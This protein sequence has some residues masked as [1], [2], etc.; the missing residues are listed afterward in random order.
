MGSPRLDGSSSLRRS[1]LVRRGVLEDWDRTRI[2]CRVSRADQSLRCLGWPRSNRHSRRSSHVQRDPWCATPRF[3]A[4]GLRIRGTQPDASTVVG[5]VDTRRGS[6]SP[7]SRS[8]CRPGGAWT[9]RECDG[10]HRTQLP[11][12]GG[13]RLGDSR[14]AS[15]RSRAGDGLRIR[16]ASGWP[17]EML[18]HGARKPE[19]HARRFAVIDQSPRCH[20]SARRTRHLTSRCRQG[21]QDRKKVGGDNGRTSF[22]RPATAV[23]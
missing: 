7:S 23:R 9:Q 22:P 18:G 3:G 19:A 8:S 10:L 13:R 15:R 16:C 17:R 20:G 1:R 6:W 2:P 5:R 12:C 4:R 21:S 14:R 11:R